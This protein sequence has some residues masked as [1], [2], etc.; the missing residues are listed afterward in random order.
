MDNLL[1]VFFIFK[2]SLKDEEQNEWTTLPYGFGLMKEHSMSW[3]MNKLSVE[4]TEE[5]A[6]E[7]Q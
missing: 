6:R 3:L 4:R 7:S 1:Q 5:R 2:T